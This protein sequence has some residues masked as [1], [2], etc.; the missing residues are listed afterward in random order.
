VF[1]LILLESFSLRTPSRAL[2][3]PPPASPAVLPVMELEPFRVKV[4]QL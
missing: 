4:P 3:T 1:W 2:R